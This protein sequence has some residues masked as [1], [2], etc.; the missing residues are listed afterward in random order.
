M[1]YD[2]PRHDVHDADADNDHPRHD[3]HDADADGHAGN[4]AND[5]S[6]LL[7]NATD[8]LELAKDLACGT[9]GVATCPCARASFWFGQ[10]R[11]AVSGSAIGPAVESDFRRAASNPDCGIVYE[12]AR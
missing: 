3:A 10:V 11:S 5:L 7:T 2:H 12:R 1:R 8:S 6:T 9:Q 4:D